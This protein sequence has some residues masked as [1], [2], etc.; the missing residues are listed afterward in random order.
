M[1]KS[2]TEQTTSRWLMRLGVLLFFLGLL[3]GLFTPGLSNPRMGS[4]SH[5]VAMMGGTFLVVLGLILPKL[6]FSRVT[7]IVMFWLAIYGTY[8]GWATRLVA[9]AWGAGGAM[10]PVTGLGK[11]GTPLQ[12]GI[13]KFGAISLVP[14]LLLMCL[15]VLWGLRGAD[16]PKLKEAS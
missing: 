7:M 16:E 4:S 13:V 11:T 6:R 5:V 2:R 3:T 10:M 8:V 1:N 12:E 14:V 15:I 9:A